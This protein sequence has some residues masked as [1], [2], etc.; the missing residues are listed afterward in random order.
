MW[1]DD[2]LAV[3]GVRPMRPATIVTAALVSLA[4]P[5][6]ANAQHPWEPAATVEQ[7]IA[8]AVADAMPD[9]R[10]PYLLRWRAFGVRGGRDIFWHLAPP[11]PHPLHPPPAGTH[12][13]AGWLSVAGG[14]GNVA[15]CG[16][17]ERIGAMAFS[18]SD[19]WLDRS[20]VIRE[21]ADKGVA[22]TLVESREA[23]LGEPGAENWPGRAYRDEATRYPAHR[24][25][26]LER[27]GREPAHLT[28][29]YQCTSPEMKHAIS[30]KMTWTVLFRPDE[31]VPGWDVC[32]AAG[33]NAYG[34]S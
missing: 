22:A 30:C 2:D 6:I 8:R 29:A 28:A 19:I 15:V 26:T 17:D 21:L 31:P 13:R 9:L 20:D 12:R 10:Y 1:G 24:L 3:P 4:F 33:G 18:V 7:A 5:A 27:D 23:D 16:D 32:L 14:Q 11:G 25:W 34:P